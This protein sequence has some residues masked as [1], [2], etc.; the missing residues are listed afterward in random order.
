[1][2]LAAAM[3]LAVAAPLVVVGAQGASA[4]QAA[5]DAARQV[6]P[7]LGSASLSSI[8]YATVPRPSYVE[9]VLTDDS[10]DNVRLSWETH[11]LLDNAGWLANTGPTLRLTLENYTI[12][13]AG[14][15]AP[16]AA[17]GRR[18]AAD[19]AA[20]AQLFVLGVLEGELVDAVSGER[21]WEGRAV[22]RMSDGDLPL[23][24][25]ALAPLFVQALGRTITNEPVRLE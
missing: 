19:P 11:H 13:A 2:S 6:A 25:L 8:A 3:S 1:M 21:L 20:G 9:V 5:Q 22:Y 7:A 24:A 14:P 4:Q 10:P 15:G 17:R 23:G 12:G 16:P 18:A